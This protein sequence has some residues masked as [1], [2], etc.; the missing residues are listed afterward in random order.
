MC[1]STLNQ[2]EKKA[3]PNRPDYERIKKSLEVR[4]DHIVE[5]IAPNV[6]SNPENVKRLERIVDV[7]MWNRLFTNRNPEYTYTNF[8]KAA[9]KFGALRLF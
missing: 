4:P 5:N 1:M 3:T 6:K 7:N 8:L 9:G 2:L